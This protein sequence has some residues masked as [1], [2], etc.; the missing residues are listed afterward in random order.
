[1]STNLLIHIVDGTFGL[2]SGFIALFA[3]NGATLHDERHQR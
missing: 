3:T 2:V 1:M